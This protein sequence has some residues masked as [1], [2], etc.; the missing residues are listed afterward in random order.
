MPRSFMKGY[1][2][3]LSVG[4]DDATSIEKKFNGEAIRETSLG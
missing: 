1:Q 2:K 4:S 3:R